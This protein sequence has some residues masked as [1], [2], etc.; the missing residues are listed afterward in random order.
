[1]LVLCGPEFSEGGDDK[2]RYFFVVN[3]RG[4]MVIE[5]LRDVGAGTL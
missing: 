3:G 4:Q 2:V 5:L 1:M